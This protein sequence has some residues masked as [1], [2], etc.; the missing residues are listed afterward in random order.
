MN[1][2]GPAVLVDLVHQGL[3]P[4]EFEAQLWTGDVE[5]GEIDYLYLSGKLNQVQRIK[6]LGRSLKLL[7]DARAFITLYRSLRL[8]KPDIV[9]THTAK[10]GLLARLA[11]VAARV[12]H[13]V[14]T[15]HGHVL[16]GYFSPRFSRAIALI[17]RFLARHTDV[18]AAVGTQVRDDLLA[19]KIGLPQQFRVV[20]PGIQISAGCTKDE[21]RRHFDLPLNAPVILFVGR[22]TRIKRPD[23]L[24]E[25][26]IKV[27]E[28]IPNALLAIAGGGDLLAETEALAAP[29]GNVVRFLGWQSDLSVVYPLADVVVLTSDNEGMPVAL[30]EASMLGIPCVTTNVGSAN[31]VVLNHVT[32]LVVAPD[33]ATIAQALVEIL[34]DRK[35]L[36]EFG[37]NARAYAESEFGSSR[38]IN[39]HSEIYRAVVSS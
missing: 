1:V 30:I 10:A 27:N 29:L 11:A 17:E 34:S 4:G 24:I 28:E 35:L 12:P 5:A 13:R 6:G 32:G 14:H 37:T 2:G 16:H 20:P 26:M 31:E 36:D 18:L 39:D 19:A 7:G 21:A 25:A 3:D 23:R 33:S 22:L 9:H 15:F 38:L 8:E